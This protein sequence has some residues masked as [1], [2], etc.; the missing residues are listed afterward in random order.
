MYKKELFFCLAILFLINLSLFGQDMIIDHNCTEIDSIPVSAIENAKDSLHIAYGHTSH[1]SQIITGMN[2]L[3]DFMGGTGLYVWN[4]GPMPDYLDIDDYFMPGDLGHN[5]DTTWANYTRSYLNDPANA[6]VNVVIWSWC[7][8]CSEN[9]ES[10]I[11]IYLNKMDELESDYSDVKFVYMTGHLDIWNWTNLKARNQQIRDYCRANDKILYDFAD[12]ESYDPDNTFFQYA[13]DN[14]D[15]YAD[16]SGSTYLG[17]WATEWQDAHTEGVDWYECTSAHSEPLNANQKAYAAWWLWARLAGWSG[18]APSGYSLNP[19]SLSFGEVYIDSSA[20]ETITITNNDS[21]SIIIDSLITSNPVFTLTDLGSK[22]AGFTLTPGATRNIDVTFTPTAVETYSAILTVYSEAAGNKTIELSGIGIEET[23]PP[24]YEVMP[25]SLS[26]GS[27]LIGN[28]AM[29]TVI[30]SN[31]DT[32]PVE[33]DSIVSDNSA[34]V[35]TDLGKSISGFTLSVGAS[36]EIRVSFTPTSDDTYSGDLTIF[37]ASVGN[38]TVPMTG[39][40]ST[41]ECHHVSG[42]VSGIWNYSNICVDGDISVTDGNTLQIIP[43]P[44]GTNIRFTGPYHFSVTGRLLAEGTASDTIFFFPENTTE[45][46]TGLGFYNTSW[47][48]MDSSRVSYCDFSYGKDTGPDA[49]GGGI[50]IYYSS[51]LQIDNCVIRNCSAN[52]GGGLYIEDSTPILKNIHLYNNTAANNGGGAYVRYSNL[53]MNYCS[54]R[55][56]SADN[57][58]GIY[59]YGGSPNLTNITLYGNVAAADGG[60]IYC[61]D[62]AGVSIQNSILWSNAPDEIYINTGSAT[63][64]YTD[65]A[66][67][68]SGTDNLNIDPLFA[69]AASGNLQLTASSP[70]IDAGNPSSPLDP[71]GTRCD[72]GAFYFDQSALAIPTNVTISLAEGTVNIDWDEVSGAASYSIYSSQ[73]PFSGFSLEVDGITTTSWS[74]TTS[75]TSKF[76]YIKAEN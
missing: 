27:V 9:T 4:D 44:G 59:F 29:D 10:G 65:I 5:G 37:S 1:G 62:W 67:G 58:A 72:M 51:T 71:D 66:G 47:N 30:I 7:G 6:D 76:Y 12:I 68:Y 14:C 43:A 60:A 28:T 39:T 23:E 38:E 57:G 19:T 15:Y 70:C 63:V 11:D 55:N 41:G 49:H 69:D 17:N 24:S 54:L 42:E 73:N 31:I 40:G 56:N 26:F 50:L 34:F 33:I 2:E 20:T 75:D 22:L 46:W 74:E 21:V 45:G 48:G 61:F 64:N 16:A 35:L 53:A 32:E 3:D 18:A 13:N 25:A 52:D 36:R 8:G